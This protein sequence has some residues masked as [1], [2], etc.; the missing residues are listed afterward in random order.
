[1]GCD[2]KYW[3]VL[4]VFNLETAYYSWQ[5]KGDVYEKSFK[6]EQWNFN[7]RIEPFETSDPYYNTLPNQTSQRSN[8]RLQK[9]S[10]VCASFINIRLIFFFDRLN[11]N[12]LN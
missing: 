9:K 11:L 12:N 2:I 8:K 3:I 5:K 10:D 6:Q 4:S 7:N 1:M